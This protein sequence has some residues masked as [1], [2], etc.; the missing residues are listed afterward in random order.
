MQVLF[1]KHF[2]LDTNR[3]HV[4]EL[5]TSL[6]H[7]MTWQK[8]LESIRCLYGSEG[9]KGA[10]TEL[11]LVNQD[12]VVIEHIKRSNEM[13]RLITEY[14]LGEKRYRQVFSISRVSEDRTSLTYVC[15]EDVPSG[16]RK[17]FKKSPPVPSFL[18]PVHFENLQKQLLLEAK[19]GA[20]ANWQLA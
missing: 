10:R 6:E 18:D 16:W 5:L 3:E 12:R 15:Q 8:S 20:P 9:A 13:V 7:R 2:L 17:I 19:V 1:E 11:T 4:W 14:K